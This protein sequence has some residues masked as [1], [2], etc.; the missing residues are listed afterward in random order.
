[1]TSTKTPA[2]DVEAHRETLV[3]HHEACLVTN[4]VPR[5]V[6]FFSEADW[7]EDSALA[8]VAR[9]GATNHEDGEKIAMMC[10]VT[11]PAKVALLEKFWAE[12]ISVAG[13]EACIACHDI[14][15]DPEEQVSVRVERKWRPTCLECIT[16]SHTD[17]DE[18]VEN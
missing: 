18:P 15:I 10:V 7:A 14:E 12:H 8:V 16:G 1:M 4:I 6:A 11:D 2:P 3:N 17:D 5:A 9:K 13:G